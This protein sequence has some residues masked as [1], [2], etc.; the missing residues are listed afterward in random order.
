MIR[1]DLTKIKGYLL[2]PDLEKY[3]ERREHSMREIEKYGIKVEWVKAIPHENNRKSA[4]LSIQ[5]ILTSTGREPILFFEDDVSSWNP[6]T[7]F[8]IPYDCDMLR[9]GNSIGVR[10]YEQDLQ[11]PLNAKMLVRVT[12]EVYRCRGMLSTHALFIFTPY[13]KRVLYDCMQLTIDDK[14]DEYDLSQA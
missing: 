9:L 5:K 3:R 14:E 1:V 10:S 6:N 11:D 2:S 12:D 4:A 8:D 7:V 13:A